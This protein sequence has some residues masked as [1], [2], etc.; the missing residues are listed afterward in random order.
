MKKILIVSL[1]L[2][3]GISLFVVYK[4]YNKPHR[5]PSSEEALKV[6]A[7]ELF[8]L[9]ESNE[10]EANSLYLDK[11]LEVSGVISEISTNQEQKIIVALETDN[12]FF[13]VRCTMTESDVNVSVGQSVSIKGICTGYLSDVVITNAV[14]TEN[15]N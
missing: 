3:I 7:V 15:N 4:L 2:V 12:S 8:K 6:S 5:D 13:G 11:V 9:Y 14:I 10:S 1:V